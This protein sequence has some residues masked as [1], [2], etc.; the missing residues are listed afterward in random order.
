VIGEYGERGHTLRW[1]KR[2]LYLRRP[3]WSLRTLGLYQVGRYDLGND[4]LILARLD[5][6]NTRPR[7]VLNPVNI[8]IEDAAAVEPGLLLFVAFLGGW[9]ADRDQGTDDAA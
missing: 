5:T 1:G 3:G 9:L 2:E 7:R 6:S 8:E 4:G